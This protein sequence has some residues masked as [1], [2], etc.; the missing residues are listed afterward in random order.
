MA[1][2]KIAKI[3]KPKNSGLRFRE[4]PPVLRIWF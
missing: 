2:I 4:N 1:D 3:Q